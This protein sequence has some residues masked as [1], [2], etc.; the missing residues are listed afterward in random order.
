M[1][2]NTMVMSLLLSGLLAACGGNDNPGQA[3]STRP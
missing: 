3:G 2:R 1:A